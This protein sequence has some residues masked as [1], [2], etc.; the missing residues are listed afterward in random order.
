MLRKPPTEPLEPLSEKEARKKAVGIVKRMHERLFAILTA[1]KAANDFTTLDDD[2]FQVEFE[3]TG[4]TPPERSRLSDIHDEENPEDWEEV[5]IYLDHG[6]VIE[7]LRLSFQYPEKS[8]EELFEL[9]RE[10]ARNGETEVERS[11]VEN[12][13]GIDL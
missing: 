7:Y 10:A 6:L 3:E 9:F 5:E 2:S 8:K 1:A 13:Y 4:L 11:V 12:I